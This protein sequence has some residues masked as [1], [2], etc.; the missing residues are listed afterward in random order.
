MEPIFELLS[1]TPEGFS[2]EILIPDDDFEFF[3]VV[4]FVGDTTVNRLGIPTQVDVDRFTILPLDPDTQEPLV[5]RG[6]SLRFKQDTGP[7]LSLPRFN[8]EALLQFDPAS[9]ADLTDGLI[10][11]AGS[12]GLDFE[13]SIFD[14]RLIGG[15]SEDFINGL[16]GNDTIVGSLGNDILLGRAGDDT[17]SGNRGTD[18]I[19]GGSDNDTL[20]GGRGSDGVRGRKGDD[21]ISGGGGR[22]L[23]LGDSGNDVL[24]GGRNGD[25]L[26]DGTGNDQLIGGGGRDTLIATSGQDS[27]DGGS[28]NDLLFVGSGLTSLT[29]GSGRDTFVLDLEPASFFPGTTSRFENGVVLDFELGRDR[30]VV[31]DTVYQSLA[32]ASDAGDLLISEFLRETAG[33]VVISS[34]S[35][36]L[37]LDGI[38]ASELSLRSFRS[39]NDASDLLAFGDQRDFEFENGIDLFF[40]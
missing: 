39:P 4:E 32:E 16:A 40:L 3:S 36:Q 34:E 33:D 31:A 12:L 7:L 11:R 24:D 6:T 20:S 8:I 35:G 19:D 28:G 21:T 26:I 22:D 1:A 2:V 15:L 38:S 27:L 30:I 37:R 17:I 10:V 14:D 5:E 13:G 23:L 29:G 25:F 9:S 18:L